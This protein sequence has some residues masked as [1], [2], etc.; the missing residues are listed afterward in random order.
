VNEAL[1]RE[2]IETYPGGV[3][4]HLLPP[5]PY[6]HTAME[7]HVN[8]CTMMLHHGKHHASFAEKLKTALDLFPICSRRQPFWLLL[9]LDTLPED[10]RVAVRNNAGGYVNH[11]L[12]WIPMSPA[13]GGARSAC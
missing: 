10:I 11:G 9:N 6:D 4:K 12:F 2:D 13:G 3:S 1:A 7:P 8:A 5:L